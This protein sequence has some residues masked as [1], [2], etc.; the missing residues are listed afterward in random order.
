MHRVEPGAAVHQVK[1]N[2]GKHCEHQH[3]KGV[4][5]EIAGME[6]TFHRHKGEDGES[7]PPGA[8]QPFLGR[9][10]GGPEVIHQHQSHGQDVKGCGAQV[11]A[12]GGG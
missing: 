7:D 2:F 11:K 5:L 8:G 1:G 10:Q 9:Q 4:F 3:P 12:A 6:V